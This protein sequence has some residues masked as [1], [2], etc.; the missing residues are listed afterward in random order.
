MLKSLRRVFIQFSPLDPRATAA[1]ELLQRVGNAASR[2]SNPECVVEYKVGAVRAP[3]RLLG[4]K[5]TSAGS[6]LQATPSYTS[7]PRAVTR[8][9]PSV[10][11]LLV[12]SRAL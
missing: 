3:A 4:A 1:R 11:P 12:P 10:Q 5:N 6:Q 9:W 2:T 7:A 8:S